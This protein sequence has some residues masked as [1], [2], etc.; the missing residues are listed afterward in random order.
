VAGVSWGGV[1]CAVRRWDKDW[2]EGVG[3]GL[4]GWVDRSSYAV[5][6]LDVKSKIY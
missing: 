3:A 4:A 6:F 2:E 1:L 5:F